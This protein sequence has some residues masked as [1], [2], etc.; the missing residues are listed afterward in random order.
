MSA[1][2]IDFILVSELCTFVVVQAQFWR[3]K[4]S[5]HNFL[6]RHCGK[7]GPVAAKVLPPQPSTERVHLSPGKQIYRH[8]IS[9]ENFIFFF[10]VFLHL[11]AAYTPPHRCVVPTCDGG[12]SSSS[13]KVVRQPWIAFAIPEEHDAKEFLTD[14]YPFDPC[15][16]FPLKNR[17]GTCQVVNF[18]QS[19]N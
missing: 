5:P 10:K 2:D 13:S 4:P 15:N 1:Q 19:I 17:N 12:D 7:L 9:H 16:R 3:G 8:T 11:F 18:L 14:G 6:G